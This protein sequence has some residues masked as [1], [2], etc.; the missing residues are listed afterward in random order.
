MIAAWSAAVAGTALDGSSGLV[1]LP[2]AETAPSGRLRASANLQVVRDFGELAPRGFPVGFGAGVGPRLEVGGGVDRSPSIGREPRTSVGTSAYARLRLVDPR[3]MLPAVALQVA[4]RGLGREPVA[5]AAAVT[6][7][8]LPH[9]RLTL[10][11]GPRL[12]S[13]G[14][15]AWG[16]AGVELGARSWSLV[17]EGD[18][19]WS[20]IGWQDLEGRG[21]V[22]AAVRDRMGLLF[23]GGGGRAGGSPWAGGGI[24]LQV[25]SADPRGQDV[26]NDTILDWNER[27][28]FEPE[29]IDGFEDADG[30]PDPDNDGD[31]IPDFSDPTPNGEPEA[32]PD[33]LPGETGTLKMRIKPRPMP[34]PVNLD[35]RGGGS[36]GPR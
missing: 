15:V 8:E 7:L 26:D 12:A 10:D 11:A 16:G 36:R 6:T 14:W 25:A 29:D 18:G 27:C 9:V 32:A 3:R 28:R 5:E 23:W 33:D 20:A 2:T 35:H 1:R 34:G 13:R 21:G 22:R 24:G 17:G 31:G 4:G 30:C 19:A